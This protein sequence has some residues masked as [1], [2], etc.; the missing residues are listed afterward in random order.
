MHFSRR[1]AELLHEDHCGTIVV[2][3]AL[4][5]MVAKAG[6]RPP[7]VSAAVTK[8]TL[9]KIANAI[10]GE[11]R[12]HFAFEENEL[13]TRL[14]DAGDGDISEHLAEEH[15]AILP[16]GEATSLLARQALADGFTDESWAAFK[17]KTGELV[18]RL[19]A[20][21]QKE[22]MALLPMLDE[23]LDAETDLA[24]SEAYGDVH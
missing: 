6:R 24:L 15:R 4:E 13:F 19:L 8:N 12:G 9:E 3:E 1:T 22:E 2:L 11:I 18:E 16:L 21:I 10:E 7:D 17:E 5:E 14:S 20:H 23:L